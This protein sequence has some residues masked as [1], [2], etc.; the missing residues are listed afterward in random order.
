MLPSFGTQ[1]GLRSGPPFQKPTNP[2]ELDAPISGLN[3]SELLAIDKLADCF[4][5]LNGIPSPHETDMPDIVFHIHAIQNIIMS[6]AAV[7]AHP[8]VLRKMSVF[9]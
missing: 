7:R 1:Q 6:R 4:N 9:K 3:Q 8:D 2:R 5:I